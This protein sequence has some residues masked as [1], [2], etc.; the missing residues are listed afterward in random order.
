[1]SKEIV[2]NGI[3]IGNEDFS[4]EKYCHTKLE[5]NLNGEKTFDAEI[6]KYV[7]KTTKRQQH[8]IIQKLKNSFFREVCGLFI[9]SPTK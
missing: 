6:Q 4:P 9:Q 5:N 3:E 1:M 7:K 2:E 8:I